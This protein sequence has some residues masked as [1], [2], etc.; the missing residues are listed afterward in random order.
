VPDNPPTPLLS[1]GTLDRLAYT[2]QALRN[3]L[4]PRLPGN[5]DLD[6]YVMAA[7]PSLI[8]LA[9]GQEN[10]QRSGQPE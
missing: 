5:A 7:M 3:R 4:S 9:A 6:G 2:V 1:S 10:P 8:L